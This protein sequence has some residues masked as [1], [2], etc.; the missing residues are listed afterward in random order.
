MFLII[1]NIKHAQIIKLKLWYL[2]ILII[3][4]ELITLFIFLINFKVFAYP[5]KP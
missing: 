5:D 4:L 2:N 3:T 1:I